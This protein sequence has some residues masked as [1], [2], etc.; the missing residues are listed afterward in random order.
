MHRRWRKNPT[1]VVK[2]RLPKSAAGPGSDEVVERVAPA[3]N[4]SSG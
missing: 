2:K 3:Q 1:R 4:R